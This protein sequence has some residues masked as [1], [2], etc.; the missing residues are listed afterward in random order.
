[1]KLTKIQIAICCGALGICNYT[2]SGEIRNITTSHSKTPILNSE[3]ST[4]TLW[5]VRIDPNFFESQFLINSNFSKF[6]NEADATTHTLNNIAEQISSDY[7]LNKIDYLSPVSNIFY[8]WSTKANISSITSDH[9]I[10]SIREIDRINQSQSIT[11][12]SKSET[13]FSKLVPVHPNDQFA[14]GEIIPWAKYSTG[15]TTGTTNNTIY[16]LDAYNESFSSLALTEM[17]LIKRWGNSSNEANNYHSGLVTGIIGAKSNSAGSQG[18]NP[19]Q[20]IMLYGTDYRNLGLFQIAAAEAMNDSE[21]IRNEFSAINIS[22]NSENPSELFS[23]KGTYGV[24]LRALSNRFLVT[25]AAGNNA[26]A[27]SGESDACLYSYAAKPDANGINTN[28]SGLGPRNNDGI[29]VVGGHTYNGSQTQ[30]LGSNEYPL[31]PKDLTTSNF[32]EIPGSNNGPCVEAWAPSDR[33]TSTNAYAGLNNRKTSTPHPL[34][35]T[36]NGTSFAAPIT[37]A[38]ATRFGNMATRPIVREAYIKK[39]LSSTGQY[40]GAN[41]AI[42]KVTIG[43]LSEAGLPKYRKPIMVR[44]PSNPANIPLLTDGKFFSG[45]SHGFPQNYG[46]LWIDLGAQYNLYGLRITI[47]SCRDGI[48]GTGDLPINF[49][50]YG[51][52]SSIDTATTPI[53]SYNEPS[54]ADYAPVF[55]PVT[56][57]Y[58]YLALDGYN[59]HCNTLNYAEVEAYTN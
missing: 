44:T 48:G 51:G 29:L 31:H 34:T 54:Q 59:A 56:G 47:R 35:W 43:N 15:A 10:M 27:S 20:P 36:M 58:R 37:A 28:T 38:I 50:V 32:L 16:V 12:N 14:N 25:E 19:G 8:A 57:S 55:I 9:R 26:A 30:Y 18:I 39:H 4:L 2:I 22:M 45:V 33:I 5:T 13:V 21:N 42:K 17:N 46:T 3:D 52:N 7:N 49:G 24:Q 6:A 1:M 11:A 23:Y 53:L 40:D 41:R